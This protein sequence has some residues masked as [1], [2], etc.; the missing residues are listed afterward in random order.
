MARVSKERPAAT[1]PKPS[2][3]PEL[4]ADAEASGN[5][6]AVAGKKR[7]VKA[8]L[9]AVERE[10][11]EIGDPQKAIDALGEACSEIRAKKQ[12]AVKDFDRALADAME[13]VRQAQRAA[14]AKFDRLHSLRATR[15]RLAAALDEA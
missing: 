15:E 13:S 9:A 14:G 12:A 7:Q 11:A 3:T 8:E 4:G 6:A 2:P 1:M 5:A 10:I